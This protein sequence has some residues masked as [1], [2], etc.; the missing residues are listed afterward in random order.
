[1]AFFSAKNYLRLRTLLLQK[2][3]LHVYLYI[4]IYSL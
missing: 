1:M 2:I 3:N 4:A